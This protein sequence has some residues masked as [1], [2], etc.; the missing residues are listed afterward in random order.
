MI[1]T[2]L[3][4]Y[5]IVAAL[6]KGGMGEVWRARDGKLGREVAIKTLPDEYASDPERLA[7]FQRE[8]R[9][10]AT[11]DHP[12]I[13]GIH[14]LEEADETRFLVLELV[15]GETLA[16]RIQQGPIPPDAALKLALQVAEALEA[17]HTK[18]VIHRDLKPSNIKITPG[19]RVKVLDFGLA[20]ALDTGEGGEGDGNISNSPTISA[21]AT[22]QGVLLGTAAYMAPEQVRGETPDPRADI[23]SFGCVLFEMLAGHR[24]FEG[25]TVSDILASILKTE[26]DWS[27][28]PSSL[29]PRIRLLLER[30]LRK[31]AGARCPRVR[32][33]RR[34][35]EKTL[36]DAHGAA[37]APK[38]HARMQPRAMGVWAAA[39]VLVAAAAALGAAYLKPAAPL[40]L[41]RFGFRAS[42][43][44][45]P[46]AVP[47][48][49]LVGIS[50]GGERVA[51]TTLDRLYV[52]EMNQREPVAVTGP[53]GWLA[54]PVFSPD[55]QSLA[56][57][58]APTPEG[59]FS[60]LRVPVGGGTPGTLATGLATLPTDLGWD[61]RGMLLYTQPD[62]IWQV[63]ASGG[64]R[65]SLVIAAQDGEE[66]ASPRFLTDGDS[67]LFAA[68][69]STGPGRWDE[70]SIFVADL[71][72]T[73]REI[74]LEGASD[75]Q[76][77]GTGHLIFARGPTL[78][79]SAFDPGSGRVTGEEFR[80]LDDEVLRS[81]NGDSDAAQYAV[82]SSGSLAYLGFTTDAIAEG[83]RS[84]VWVNREGDEEAIDVRPDRYVQAR[85]S[86]DGTK[87]SLVIGGN[88]I[89]G[90]AID[91]WI[92]DLE[93]GNLSTLTSDGGSD[94]VVWMPDS[95][96]VLFRSGTGTARAI[97]SMSIEGGGRESVD[98]TSE[99]PTAFPMDLTPDGETLVALFAPSLNPVLLDLYTV[100]LGGGG[101]SD[102]LTDDA[103]NETLP[104]ISP[105]GQ[106]IAYQESPA[107]DAGTGEVNIRP[108]PEVGLRR[109]PIGPGTTPVFS[110]DGTELY[111]DDLGG[112]TAVPVSYAP[113]DTGTREPLFRR[114]I[115]RFG[116]AGRA[117]D[118]A[119]DGRF[120]MIKE[121]AP[122]V[123]GAPQGN[124]QVNVV[125]SFSEVLAER[126]P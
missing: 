51:Y 6:G 83:D 91:V 53:A 32:E 110:R 104:S 117:W 69:T 70:A 43:V 101:I 107:G 92:L 74:V 114:D 113:F 2:S 41:M 20:K 123:D 124:L 37:V 66:L 118:V 17:A 112:I 15:E 105:S 46:L 12:N 13:A 95:E 71:G 68:T 80:V 3:A 39:T 52:R 16:E 36:A 72:S 58:G 25:R 34:E 100:K 4:H 73:D 45:R 94:A 121:G 116:P 29:H 119:P 30:C 11:L 31:D 109:Y 98:A 89:T 88:T 87:V 86:P 55:G 47:P 38:T 28:L 14:G 103:V 78:W 120:L 21:S 49:S 22:R 5:E 56:Y 85:I 126:E 8:A 24:A 97:Y 82:S 48:V 102:L 125:V 26:P 57:V 50:A 77:T 54:L 84:L 9:F 33:V 106:F 44:S 42:D 59:P 7:R 60:I 65:A 122:D 23:W 76:Y 61:D 35:I 40:P 62:G 63:S 99:I 18:G 1:G 67:V 75:P 10:L 96:H 19:D 93:T 90:E 64:G 79:A 81:P 115:Y 108:F 111:Y 27:R